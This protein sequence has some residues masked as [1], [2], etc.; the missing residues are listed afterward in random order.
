MQEI[1]ALVPP[2]SSFILVDENQLGLN[3]QYKDRCCIKFIEQDG[4]YWGPPTNDAS[5][6]EEIER[7]RQSGASYIIFAWPAFWWLEYYIEMGRYLNANYNCIVDTERL[8]GF[9]LQ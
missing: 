1:T 9:I 3:D 2:N 6:I 4:Q 8:K 5:A 7:L